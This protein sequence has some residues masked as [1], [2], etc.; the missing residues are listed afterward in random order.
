[1]AKPKTP[2]EGRFFS[3]VEQQGECWVWTGGGNGTGYGLFYPV[4]RGNTLAHRWSWVFFRGPIPDG[5]QLDHL[6]RN[7]RCVNPDHLDPVTPKVNTQRAAA[8]I[9][10]CP[11]G[12]EYTPDNTMI[13]RNRRGWEMRNCK[14]CNAD[15][16]RA[17]RRLNPGRNPLR[18]RRPK[19]E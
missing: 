6:C 15:R 3:K 11:Q 19:G 17:W 9:A 1:M 7:K 4:K 12:H 2:P 5:L 10:H 8:L 14:T 18:N 13:S 16:A